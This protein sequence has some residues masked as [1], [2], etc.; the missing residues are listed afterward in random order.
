MNLQ[1]RSFEAICIKDDMIENHHAHVL[2]IYATSTF[3]YED[4][5]SAMDYFKG[6]SDTHAYSRMSNPTPDFVAKKIAQLEGFDEEKSLQTY[7]VLFGSGMAAISSAILACIAAGQKVVTTNNIYG[8][9]NQFLA[10]TLNTLGV[11]L[12][13]SDLKDLDILEKLLE[14]D[15]NIKVIYIETPTNPT[16]ECYDLATIAA[17]AKKY[18]VFT[19]VDNTF[20][21]P[22]LQ[23]PLLLG[24]DI[25]VHSGTKF[26][27]GHGTGISGVAVTSDESLYKK[28]N[29]NKKV[30]GGICSPFEAYLLNNGIRTLCIR[31]KKHQENAQQLAEFLEQHPKIKKVNYLGL[32]SHADHNLAK[33]QMFGFGGML[34]FEIDGDFDTAIQF[35]KNI[36]FCTVTA[37]LGTTDTLLTHNAST[38]HSNVPKEQ[39]I[40]AGISDSLIRCSVGIENIR[41]VINDIEQALSLL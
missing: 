19:I 28:I 29:Q 36:K 26:L 4:I 13:Y 17:I 25:V 38:S 10:S 12:I 24:F 14:S 33:K 20:S 37:T 41:D 30:F 11:G 34:S 7:G 8:T 3:V 1:K 35:M 27:N 23:R 39:R 32:K 6:K 31:M 16:L 5:E 18:D 22:Y 2:P 40:A 9:S 15:K 21:T